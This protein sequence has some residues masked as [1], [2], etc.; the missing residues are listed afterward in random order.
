MKQSEMNSAMYDLFTS[1]KMNEFFTSFMHEKLTS[2]TFVEYLILREREFFA[3]HRKRDT[4]LSEY[5]PYNTGF[6]DKAFIE[7][8]D[9]LFV[10]FIL[11][12]FDMLV[13]RLLDDYFDPPNIRQI[14]YHKLE[15]AMK[16][17]I[18]NMLMGFNM[19]WTKCSISVHWHGPDAIEAFI[20]ITTGDEEPTE[21][22]TTI[23][24]GFRNMTLG[25]A[26]ALVNYQVVG[27]VVNSSVFKTLVEKLKQETA[28]ERRVRWEFEKG[29]YGKFRIE[30]LANYARRREAEEKQREAEIKERLK[31]EEIERR[32]KERALRLQRRKQERAL[33]LQRL[34]QEK[35]IKKKERHYVQSSLAYVKHQLE[36]SDECPVCLDKIEADNL[37][38][39]P[40]HHNYCRVC[41]I[42]FARNYRNCA[43]CRQGVA[44]CYEFDNNNKKIIIKRWN[45]N[46]GNY[47]LDANAP[48]LFPANLKIEPIEDTEDEKEEEEDKEEDDDDDEDCNNNNKDISS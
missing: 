9:D 33:R 12:K 15:N 5:Y 43:V 10:S 44:A 2:I 30:A 39:S 4:R 21:T 14:R 45:G 24:T 13:C 19:T 23:S 11:Y 34:K 16:D 8:S 27:F 22:R 47:D 17:Y 18:Q 35:E 1:S 31:Q 36:R 38:V 32:K 25:T 42:E 40:C 7:K 28:Q 29:Q 46:S 37:V 48:M 26:M 41:F 3:S 20:K 6:D